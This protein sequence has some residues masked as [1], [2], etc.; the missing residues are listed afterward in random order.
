MRA[1]LL[2]SAQ[3]LQI[4][5]QTGD[6]QEITGRSRSAAGVRSWAGLRPETVMDACPRREKRAILIDRVAT[7]SCGWTCSDW[8]PPGQNPVCDHWYST[9]TCGRSNPAVRS[10]WDNVT[11]PHRGGRGPR[12]RTRRLPAP[13]RS[14]ARVDGRANPGE[15]LINVVN[16]DKPKALLGLDQKVSGQ[17]QGLSIPLSS[18]SSHRRTGRA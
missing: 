14:G 15:L 12:E 3:I 13:R 8:F 1:L 5:A 9:K 2:N 10:S 17:V 6:R 4:R 11:S 16:Q 7:R 18:L